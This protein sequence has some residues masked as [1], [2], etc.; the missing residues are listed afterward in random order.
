MANADLISEAWAVVD[1]LYDR[2]GK[3]YARGLDRDAA[4]ILTKLIERIEPP[5]DKP[6]VRGEQQW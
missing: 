6:I 5:A 4:V 3:S 1:R 2:L